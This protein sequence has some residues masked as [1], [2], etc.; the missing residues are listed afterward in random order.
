MTTHTT[1]RC[2]ACNG[3]IEFESTR[4]GETITC[5]WCAQETDLYIPGGLARVEAPPPVPAPIPVTLVTPPSPPGRRIKRRDFFGWWSIIEIIG[6]LIFLP[7]AFVLV[8]TL[9]GFLTS[10]GNEPELA[11]AA[12]LGF[13]LAGLPA[14]VGFCMILGAHRLATTWLCGNCGNKLSDR[15]AIICAVCHSALRMFLL[16]VPSVAFCSI[17]ADQ[18]S[19]IGGFVGNAPKTDTT[20]RAV[21]PGSIHPY[22]H[23]GGRYWNISPLF[24]A[25]STIHPAL[26]GWEYI[27][28]TVA[29]NGH[30]GIFLEI[31]DYLHAGGA[32]VHVF[33]KNYPCEIPDGRKI[34]LYALRDGTM[35]YR[36]VMGSTATVTQ[37]DYGEPYNPFLKASTNTVIILTNTVPSPT[38]TTNKASAART[39]RTI[40]K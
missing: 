1:C 17:Q 35:Q 13:I 34:H 8:A 33:V 19:R 22:R 15:A 14:L 24:T 5:P 11:G 26:P 10:K 40:Y 31:H 23:A 25:P 36:T 27:W 28:G 3:E 7:A 4:A 30:G 2:A 32:T 37:Y 20:V 18:L 6:Y 38:N 16:F 29:Q 21:R 9:V 39:S 12:V